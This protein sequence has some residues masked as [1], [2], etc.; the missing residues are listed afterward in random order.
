MLAI[1]PTK[2]PQFLYGAGKS[3]LLQNSD[4]LG[5]HLA[6]YDWTKTSQTMWTLAT[7]AGALLFLCGGPRGFG[8]TRGVPLTLRTA[9]EF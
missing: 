9:E 3:L 2:N 6:S 5:D 8:A 7:A 1:S 4:T